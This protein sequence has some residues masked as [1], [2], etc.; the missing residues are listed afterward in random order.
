MDGA[1]IVNRLEKVNGEA[2]VR[3]R[4]LEPT[5]LHG[6]TFLAYLY[7]YPYPYLQPL[8]FP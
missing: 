6:N 2:M 7:P 5:D 4:S 3:P 8:P 1:V